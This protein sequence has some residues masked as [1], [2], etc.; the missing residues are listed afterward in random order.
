MNDIEVLKKMLIP[1]VLVPLQHEQD[2]RSSVKLTDLQAQTAV[3]IKGL[4]QNTVVLRAEVFIPYADAEDS[5]ADVEDRKNSCFFNGSKGECKRADFVIVS[6]GTK[7]WII[8]IETQRGNYKS[9]KEVV[10][11]LKGALCLINYCRSIGKE[12][13][14]EGNY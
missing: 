2:N 6:S 3:T 8:F 10:Q 11:Q 7:K 13:W 1:S 4:P 14:L 9:C 12:F 5:N